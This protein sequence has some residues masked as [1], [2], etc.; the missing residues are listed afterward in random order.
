MVLDHHR[1]LFG[2]GIQAL[3]QT[4]MEE[5]EQNGRIDGR[6]LRFLLP[7]RALRGGI[8]SRLGTRAGESLEF[9]DYRDYTPGDDL[10]N[11]DW[12]VLAR[13][14]RE[15][16]RVRREEVAPVV[17]VFRDRSAS[18]D[19]PPTKHGCADWLFGLLV[20]SADGC[21][22]VERERPKTPRAVRVYVTDTFLPEDP[23][24]VLARLAHNSATFAVV[25]ILSR[26]ETS[27]TPGGTFELADSETGE[28]R[29]ITM[30]PATLAKYHNALDMHTA[31][32][33]A[34]ITRL[35]ATFVDLVAEA[36]RPERIAALATAGLVEGRG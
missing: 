26:E 1:G 7:R 35:G 27:P 32:W 22:V 25:R 13:T 21:R 9:Q 6:G 2:L 33:T 14:E 30:D 36:S 23:D 18:M 11:L 29:E 4:V 5:D 12:T 17:E 34:A 28:R 10:R 19:T 3:S 16:V 20:A 24:A 31:R 8:G 15:V